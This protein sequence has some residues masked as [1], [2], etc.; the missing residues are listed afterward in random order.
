MNQEQIKEEKSSILTLLLSSILLHILLIL[1]IIFYRLNPEPFDIKHHITQDDQVILWTEQ[2]PVQPK[3]IPVKQEE[4]KQAPKQQPEQKKI[5]E[6]KVQQPIIMPG[7]QG[8]DEQ[9]ITEEKSSTQDQSSQDRQ[10]NQKIE[11]PA[12]KDLK[13]EEK[14]IEDNPIKKKNSPD[15]KPILHPKALT[16]IE[17]P[18]EKTLKFD[19]NIDLSRKSK[20]SLEHKNVPQVTEK[21]SSKSISFKDISLGFNNAATNIGNSQHLMIQGTSP[22]IPQGEELKYLTFIN[23]M[24]NMIVTSMHTNPRIRMLPHNVREK[25][26]CFMK[27]NRSGQLLDT[28]IVSPSQHDAINGFIIESIKNVGLFNKIP[29]FIAKDTFEINWHILT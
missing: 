17:N 9:H 10:K 3:A 7:K 5:P 11:P 19:T 22:D 23:Q 12:P 4:P 15:Q 18:T 20:M 29:N 25:I 26:I 8:I 14:K 28:R 2:A 27:I 21:K 24:A 6:P 13:K 16:I 1:I